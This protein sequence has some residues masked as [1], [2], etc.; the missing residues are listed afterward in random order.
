MRFG[1]V[2]EQKNSR[3]GNMCVKSTLP[4][5]H[6]VECRIRYSVFTAR[7]SMDK[8]EICGACCTTAAHHVNMSFTLCLTN[9]QHRW[10]EFQ[11]HHYHTSPSSHE[12][13]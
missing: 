4:N 13:T 12:Y 5:E 7:V 3:S 6:T 2:K 10:P 11:Y 8:R 9:V 1:A